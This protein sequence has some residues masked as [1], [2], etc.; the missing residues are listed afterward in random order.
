[1]GEPIK[2]SARNAG[3][4]AI[5]EVAYAGSYRYPV[6]DDLLDKIILVD[7][8][9]ARALNG[10]VDSSSRS[11]RLKAGDDALLSTGDVDELFAT[12]DSPSFHGNESLSLGAVEGL[13]GETP[14]ETTANP[15]I[16]A[17]TFLLVRTKTGYSEDIVRLQVAK[18][19]EGQPV[20][21][22]DW[23]ASA[24]GNAQLVYLVRVMFN[25]GLVLVVLIAIF[26]MTNSL[27]LSVHERTGE[28][29]TMRAVGAT[30]GFVARLLTLETFLLVGGAASVG[31]LLGASV[32]ATLGT[33]GVPLSNPLIA[34]LFGSKLLRPMVLWDQVVLHLFVSL[35]IGALALVLP[36][37]VALAIP[38][39]AA[40]AKDS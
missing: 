14:T 28:I 4:F 17:W 23:R 21:V 22:R 27:A 38:P 19:T 29:G 8:D 2:L 5:R 35:V 13:L 7:P 15:L 32:I 1:V 26:V 9:T 6:A 11:V 30:R 16:G 24:G 18:T 3:G 25:V 36:L 33:L 34:A 37:R 20:Q 12:G 40:M 39:V 31:L 10:Y